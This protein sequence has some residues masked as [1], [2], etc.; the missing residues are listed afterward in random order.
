M[1]NRIRRHLSTA[2]A[3]F[4]K[5][6][7]VS[8]LFLP[9]HSRSTLKLDEHYIQRVSR[10]SKCKKKKERKRKKDIK[11]HGAVIHRTG[12]FSDFCGTQ[13]SGSASL[14]VC[15]REF[16][17]LGAELEKARK[18][19]CFSFVVFSVFSAALGVRRRGCDDERRGRAGTYWGMSSCKYSGVVPS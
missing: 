15:G 1:S 18:P 19:N 12:T 4:L 10:R 2:V 6:C 7:Q 8:P 13:S 16:Q 9:F 17:S 11:R 14:I 3:F 5:L